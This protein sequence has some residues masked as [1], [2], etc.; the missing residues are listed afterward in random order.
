MITPDMTYPVPGFYVIS[1]ERYIHHSDEISDNLMMRTSLLIKYLRKALRETL[2]IE[3]CNLYSDEKNRRANSLHYWLVPKYKEFLSD[4]LDHKLMELNLNE[5]MK[6]FRT[7]Y[8]KK[9]IREANK[10]IKEYFI[11]NNLKEKDDQVYNISKRSMI[12]SVTSK[13]NRK[14]KGCYNHFREDDLKTKDWLNFIDY[15]KEQ[16]IKKITISGGDPLC[17]NDIFEILN[18]CLKKE[19]I[20]NLD[21]VGNILLENDNKLQQK[22]NNTFSWD[23]LKKI[24]CIGIPLDGAS[25]NVANKFR[26]EQENFYENQI[27]LIKKL[28]KQDC[29]ISINTVMHKKNIKDIKNIYNVLKNMKIKK[30]QIFQFMGIGKIAS[31][32]KENFSID[33]NNFLTKQK[34]IMDYAKDCNFLINFKSSN[35]R[36]GN[37]IIID[38]LGEAY[39][40]ENEENY[41]KIIGN[42]FSENDKKNIIDTYHFI[43]KI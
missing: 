38:S 33:E 7:Y 32:N 12:L 5:Y 31:K 28:L 1:Y 41:H 13:C 21:T 15:L 10:K 25:S 39:L 3:C 6:K 24:N 17:R 30:W 2:G 29:S 23:I 36:L 27:K 43:G 35:R 4:G 18:Y 16:G 14:C 11:I 8:H 40:V 9:N 26:N 42:I 22:Y 20:V 34:Q 19:F 37:Y